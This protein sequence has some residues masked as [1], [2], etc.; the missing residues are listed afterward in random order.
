MRLNEGCYDSG[1]SGIGRKW[2]WGQ[3]RGHEIQDLPTEYLYW[4]VCNNDSLSRFHLEWLANHFSVCAWSWGYWQPPENARQD[5]P[6]HYSDSK[7]HNHGH[8]TGR[9]PK[10]PPITEDLYWF[11]MRQAQGY[12]P[13]GTTVSLDK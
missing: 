4:H 10:S 2:S 3:W 13:Q 8:Y 12:M 6:G 5:N 11:K 7:G 1:G 9:G